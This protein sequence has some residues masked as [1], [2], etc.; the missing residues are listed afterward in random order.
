MVKE[1]PDRER[2]WEEGGRK[3]R[4]TRRRS[5]AGMKAV[6]REAFSCG[7]PKEKC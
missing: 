3:R 6:Q 4:R 2:Q 5:R 1:R 7:L